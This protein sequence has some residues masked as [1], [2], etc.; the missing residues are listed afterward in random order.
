MSPTQSKKAAHHAPESE[1]ELL[2]CSNA[3][4]KA[5]DT[6]GQ[7]TPKDTQEETHEEM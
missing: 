6:W 3:F 2:M 1:A 4:K 7:E 5:G